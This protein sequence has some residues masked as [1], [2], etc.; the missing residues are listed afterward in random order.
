VT[1]KQLPLI[2]P[3]KPAKPPKPKRALEHPRHDA[4][5]VLV[6]YHQAL[7]SHLV[8]A[9][10]PTWESAVRIESY[11]GSWKKAAKQCDPGAVSAVL[12]AW[13]GLPAY[14]QRC[15]VT[16]IAWFSGQANAAGIMRRCLA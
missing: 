7:T 16:E 9:L 15:S 13:A 3:A 4:S 6:D 14:L 2:G 1:K 8:E 11:W 5:G 10:R 12:A